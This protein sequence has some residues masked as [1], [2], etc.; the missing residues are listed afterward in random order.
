MI[1]CTLMDHTRFSLSERERYAALP[2]AEDARPHVLLKTC[3]RIERYW[4]EGAVTDGVIRH[5]YRVAAGL[6]SSLTGER[7]IQGQLKTAYLEACEKYR[8]SAPMHRLFQTAM[9]TGKRVRTET[10]I[11]EG[12]VSHSQVTVEILKKTCPELNRQVVSIIG[13]NKLTEDILKFLTDRR[14]MTVFLSNRRLD[15]AEQLAAK[16]RA[17]AISLDEKKRMLDFTDILICATSAPHTIIH[18]DD[19][20]EEKEL[21]VFDLAFPRDVEPALAERKGVQLFDLEQ[22]EQFAKTNLHLRAGEAAK[23]ERLID[24]EIVKFREWETYVNQIKNKNE[25]LC[26][27]SNP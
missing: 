15:R 3:N 25:C 5:L 14:T 24:E 16:Y 10:R 19:L 21:L 12:A 27:E 26:N 4:G 13:V 6:E 11:A 22:I 23:A 17:T 2:P 8:L 1:H 20:P 7:A 18:A 9:H